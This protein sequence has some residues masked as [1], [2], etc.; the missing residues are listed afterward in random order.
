MSNYLNGLKDFVS[1][2]VRNTD[3]SKDKSNNTFSKSSESSSNSKDLNY[4]V[5]EYE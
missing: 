5:S 2:M 3:V 4:E 1:V